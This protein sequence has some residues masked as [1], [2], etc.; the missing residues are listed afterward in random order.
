MNEVMSVRGIE[1]ICTNSVKDTRTLIYEMVYENFK[2]TYTE[3][4]WLNCKDN[5][6]VHL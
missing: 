3:P 6:M 1:K 2:S 5:V 4:A